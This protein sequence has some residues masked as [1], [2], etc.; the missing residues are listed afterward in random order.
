MSVARALAS[1]LNW[2]RQCVGVV[3]PAVRIQIGFGAHARRARHHVVVALRNNRNVA[4]L[5]LD[6]LECD[7]ADERYPACS[8]R[9]QNGRA[10]TIAGL[11]VRARALVDQEAHEMSRWLTPAALICNLPMRCRYVGTAQ[12]FAMRW[13]L[14]VASV[15]TDTKARQRPIGARA[16]RQPSDLSRVHHMWPVLP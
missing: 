14:V 3:G 8:A 4:F 7:V 6:R 1:G 9:S 13:P 12:A 2:K 5:K 15:E 11:R 16:R 10:T